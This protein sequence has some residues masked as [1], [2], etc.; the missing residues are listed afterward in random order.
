MEKIKKDASRRK[1]GQTENVQANA[2][3]Q[4]MSMMARTAKSQLDA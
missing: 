4:E 3:N 1:R 2:V